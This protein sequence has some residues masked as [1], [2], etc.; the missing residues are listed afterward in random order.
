MF[1]YEKLYLR[2]NLH[3]NYIPF[4][5]KVVKGIGLLKVILFLNKKERGNF[6]FKKIHN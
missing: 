1:L 2:N 5:V 3:G 4:T 6:A